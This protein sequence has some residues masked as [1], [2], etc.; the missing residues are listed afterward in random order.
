MQRFNDRV[1]IDNGSEVRF[2]ASPTV[3]VYQSGSVTLAAIYDDDGVTVKANPFTGPATGLIYFYAADGKYDINYTGGSPTLGSTGYTISAHLLDDTLS[4]SGQ[5]DNI[6]SLNGLVAATQT[7]VAGTAGSDFAVSSSGSVHTFNLPTASTTRR[8]ALS[9]AD[10]TTF[11]NKLTSLNAL[12]ATVQALAIG[13]SGSSPN[14]SSATA[15]HTLNIPYASNSAAG[16]LSALQYQSF[17]S[18][19]PA[20]P[21]GNSLQYWRGDKVFATLN[22]AIVPES[23]NLYF[24]NTRARAALSATAPVTFDSGTGIIAAQQASAAQSGYIT[25]ADYADWENNRIITLNNQSQQVQTF[26]TDATGTDFA[27]VSTSANHMWSLP[28]A[29]PS[30]T[31]GKITNAAQSLS[32][33]KTFFSVLT[34]ASG[35]KRSLYVHTAPANVTMVSNN[36]VVVINKS[37]ASATGVT[38]PS[39]P[40]TGQSHIIIDGLGDAAGNNITI[41][42]A[43]GTV[44][45][46]ASVQITA[47]YGWK[48]LIY[49]GTEW[50]A[51]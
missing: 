46:A 24:T 35:R 33:E 15:T 50:N 20:I 43:A 12:T 14:W 31:G 5:S 17:S 39:S 9:S 13:T 2:V 34:T 45:G 28:A 51:R 1:L 42:P 40:A 21:A 29:A 30:V 16:I 6:T 38:L 10:F 26:S 19:E 36:E 4:M 3:T 49:N 7:F 44:N 11:S 48:E 47:N 23:G 8:G 37:T 27:V 25:A 18:K 22:T 32:G 41:T